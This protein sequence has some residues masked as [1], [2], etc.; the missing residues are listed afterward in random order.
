MADAREL[1]IKLTVDAAQADRRLKDIAK[2]TGQ[3]EK[4]LGAAGG[5]LKGFIG[6]LVGAVSIGAMVTA[7][8][9]AAD[10]M[11][12]M[13]KASQKIGVSV[14]NL[15]ALNYA[16][17]QSGVSF[18]GLQT[19]LRK[20]GKELVDVEKGTS[21]AAKALRA[22]GV[23]GADSPEQAL[24]KI[25]DA[26]ASVPDSTQKTT[27]A[28]AIF[29]KAGADLIPLLNAGAEGLKEFEDRAKQLGIVMDTETAK[30]AELFNDSLDDMQAALG[31]IVKN[32]V[33]GALPGM[34]GL[35]AA[36]AN[37]ARASKEWQQLGRGLAEVLA[38]VA[39]TG[40]KAVATF[41]GLGTVIAG[42]AAA[43]TLAASGEFK[44]AGG[45]LSQMVDDVNGIE[46]STNQR[47]A[48][49]REAFAGIGQTAEPLKTAAGSAAAMAN[50]VKQL[51]SDDKPQK[52]KAQSDAMRD[53]AKALE[54]AAAIEAEAQG[55]AEKFIRGEAAKAE[56]LQAQIDA[57]EDMANPM[58]EYTRGQA[59][60]YA[61]WET[62]KLSA[63]G[64][65]AGMAVLDD[66]LQSAST[67]AKEAPKELDD[68][69]QA[70]KNLAAQGIGGL[71]DAIF[72]ADQNFKEFAGNFLQ[73]IAKMIIQQQIFNALKG[74]TLGGWLGLNAKGNAFGGAT[75]LPHGVYNQPTFFNMPGNGPL[76]KFARGGVLGEAGPEA[77]LPLRR[78]AG[79]KLGV[80]AAPVNVN[81]INNAG[82]N[83]GVE[84][85]GNDI[86]IT[87]ERV[88]NA[89]TR[90][91]RAGG[92]AFAGALQNTYGLNRASA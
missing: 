63:E 14:E 39:G 90:D 20:L 46:N 83:V 34:S 21:E 3:L 48:Q 78:G 8:K 12:E 51:T 5:A 49:M 27:L 29:G 1:L 35:A 7:F 80:D 88:R 87:I 24:S 58:R 19:G 60:L 45:A 52:L 6:G 37:G 61:L 68:M 4:R 64:L 16:A 18:E 43:A 71:V 57:L 69:Q 40:V 41:Q 42:V 84:K 91:I 73:Q 67:I 11:D 89:L 32:I 25:A 30:K 66:K 28:M 62:G 9:S 86:N 10:A 56:A 81:V 77:I 72:K 70:M 50:A 38:F 82:V 79:G 65:A 85:D 92:N 74:T 75:G 53:Y 2:S 76:Q 59:E 55:F 22:L 13:S 54:Q 31:G 15:S 26:F 47:L 33:S 36:M 17:S 44:A 23:K